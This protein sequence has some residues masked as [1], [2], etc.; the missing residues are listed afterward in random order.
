MVSLFVSNV[1][2]YIFLLIITW[3][4]FCLIVDG[5]G[6]VV[7]ACA[8]LFCPRVLFAVRRMTKSPLCVRNVYLCFVASDRMTLPSLIYFLLFSH[9][10]ILSSFWTSRDGHRCRPPLLPGSCLQFLSRIGSS[11]PT[12]RRFFIECCQLTPSRFPHVKMRARKSTHEFKRVCTRGD[13]NSR[14]CPI[15]GSRIT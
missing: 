5:F 13:S 15:P 6:L 10:Y 14:K 7:L 1:R 4:H 12:V 8:F 2:H 9:M 3:C 11:N